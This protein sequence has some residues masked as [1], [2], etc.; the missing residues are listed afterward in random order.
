MKNINLSPI[1]FSGNSII[2][3]E[4]IRKWTLLFSVLGFIFVGICIV[5]LPA[6]IIPSFTGVSG[7]NSIV[8]AMPFLGIAL[9]YFFP[10]YFL[11]KFSIISRRAIEL[12][13]P[14]Y[15]EISFRFLKLHYRFMGILICIMLIVYLIAGIVFLG[16][17]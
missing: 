9:I 4:E 11:L 12:S 6:M 2:H 1:E 10:L 7:K 8:T 14:K 13:D 15:L 16:L 5:I 17:K 3:L